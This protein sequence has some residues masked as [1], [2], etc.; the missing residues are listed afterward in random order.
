[1]EGKKEFL[2]NNQPE[3]LNKLDI[4]NKILSKFNYNI[5]LK[6]IE[7]KDEKCF[8]L[9]Q[10]YNY[11]KQP[12]EVLFTESEGYSSIGSAYVNITNLEN[13]K[14]LVKE[15]LVV[16]NNEKIN[17][18]NKFN[19]STTIFNI[20]VSQLYEYK[21][22]SNSNN[23][24]VIENNLLTS[25]INIIDLPSA[26]I[27]I[28][29]KN[30]YNSDEYKSIFAFQ[31]LISEL[32]KSNLT[33][34]IDPDVY[35]FSKLTKLLK[36][37]IGMN[38]ICF[39]I[40]NIKNSNFLI[41]ELIFKI[42]K[43]TQKIYCYPIINDKISN[44]ICRRFRNEINYLKNEINKINNNVKNNRNINQNYQNQLKSKDDK[45]KNNIDS[46][47][48]F[49]NGN[50]NS[51]NLDNNFPLVDQL[52]NKIKINEQVISRLEQELRLSEEEKMKILNNF[53][54]NQAGKGNINFSNNMNNHSNSYRD[55]NSLTYIDEDI[56]EQMEIMNTLNNLQEKLNLI[57]N[58][59]RIIEEDNLNMKSAYVRQTNE[60]EKIKSK[61]SNLINNL[62]NEILQ[63]KNLL[64]SNKAEIEFLRNSRDNTVQIKDNMV[65][66]FEN[67]ENI[68]EDKINE[69]KREYE[70]RIF[71]ENN[72]N[73]KN[74]EKI[75]RELSLKNEN[76]LDET[77]ELKKVNQ[78]LVDENRRLSLH[79]DEIRNNFKDLLSKY[80]KE[81][82]KFNLID[83]N[84][85][86]IN[87]PVNA[88][89]N[90]SQINNKL[91]TSNLSNNKNIGQNKAPSNVPVNNGNLANNNI[92]NNPNSIKNKIFEQRE[93]Y[94]EV[95]NLKEK[96]LEKNLYLEKNK[97][98]NLLDKNKN[99]KLM[100]RKLKNLVLD[101]YPKSL[102]SNINKNNLNNNQNNE[103][104]QIE[105]ILFGDLDQNIDNQENEGVIKFYE[106]E[107]KQL[108]ER[109]ISLENENNKNKFQSNLN[110]ENKS[111]SRNY[112]T[113][114]KFKNNNQNNSE[115]F[116]N[117]IQLKI[118]EE[119]EK[120][121]VNNNSQ[122]SWHKKELDKIKYENSN[123]R[124]EII[125]LKRQLISSS[126]FLENGGNNNYNSNSDMQQNDKFL[127]KLQIKNDYLEKTLTKLE[128][129][130]IE[131]KI[132]ANSAEEQLSNLQIYISN[133]NKMKNSLI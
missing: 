87:I 93:K 35:E 111:S 116:E 34:N 45:F 29:N 31:N 40:F 56:R 89:L 14:S 20:E 42:M 109:I 95:L 47:D 55:Q 97:Y 127:K 132:R 85:P 112:F 7:L 71:D 81:T 50:L 114:K 75:K 121:K 39:A 88:S 100:I 59:K 15:A 98:K 60:I 41:N 67:K 17:S 123:L 104:N 53:N 94:F 108:R 4:D 54:I 9:L 38:S 101:Y 49:S 70:N 106:F 68:Y 118:L 83:S 124:E 23:E 48:I 2:L 119:I 10:K 120:L 1:M 96:D 13:F 133:L 16:K 11:F 99:L 5:K 21:Y 12:A 36:E 82:Q 128:K 103:E 26:N 25:K 74:F 91:N 57:I 24:E 22:S 58:E 79:N 130:N 69:I 102:P 51:I 92:N 84:K 43:L 28:E 107:L 78:D 37:Y 86:N 126:K 63:L 46:D 62:N 52:K 3:K 8:D 30:I 27:L 117:N 19:K 61:N 115:N 33:F 131:L 44:V 66:S 90:N 105:Q 18:N 72:N 6:F 125:K 110:N 113:E 122:S 76:L 77:F 80:D 32:V 64:N 65:E 129:E 73:F